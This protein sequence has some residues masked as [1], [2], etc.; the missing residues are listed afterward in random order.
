MKKLLM[1]GVLLLACTVAMATD[2]PSDP[3]A[4]SYLDYISYPP[5]LPLSPPPSTGGDWWLLVFLA[6]V[7][8]LLLWLRAAWKP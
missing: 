7:D 8:G 4:R 3:G 5:V 2:D 6:S 1:I